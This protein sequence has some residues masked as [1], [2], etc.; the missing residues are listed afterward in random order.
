MSE[1]L[2]KTASKSSDKDVSAVPNLKRKDGNDP[3][4]EDRRESITSTLFG[5]VTDRCTGVEDSLSID[6]DIPDFANN[7]TN[8]F[9]L[10]SNVHY[11]WKKACGGTQVT[12]QLAALK[13]LLSRV[14]AEARSPQSLFARN[15]KHL[16]WWNNFSKEC[17]DTIANL[18]K[19]LEKH[20]DLGRNPKRNWERIQ[21]KEENVS[22][23][24][25]IL[26]RKR[27]SHPDHPQ[28]STR[29]RTRPSDNTEFNRENTNST[30]C[31]TCSSPSP[32]FTQRDKSGKERRL[33]TWEKLPESELHPLNEKQ[34]LPEGW[35]WRIDENNRLFYVDTH[36]TIFGRIFWK[37][38]ASKIVSY[39]HPALCRQFMHKRGE[40][41][42][43][44]QNEGGRRVFTKWTPADSTEYR[45]DDEEVACQIESSVWK[46]GL[47]D[48]AVK[49]RGELWWGNFS[50]QERRL[51]LTPRSRHS[52]EPIFRD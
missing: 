33:I 41:F 42:L 2:A 7:V 19:V 43:L 6:A 38:R 47:S 23:L 8:F 24:L 46:D 18:E 37:H 12:K 26:K 9:N 44:R 49:V 27:Y 28:A 32:G 48:E 34:K 52:S 36:C 20:K 21:R 29:E 13:T 40:L 50:L 11:R 10:V 3:D 25:Q 14:E 15:P 1:P 4:D 31:S 51:R 16:E 35:D 30:G 17:H 45:I 39:K 5:E 22:D